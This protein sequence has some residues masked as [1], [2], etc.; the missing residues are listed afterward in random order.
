[1]FII[2]RG[3][4]VRAYQKKNI[5]ISNTNDI[6][7]LFSNDIPLWASFALENNV[8]K[9]SVNPKVSTA[10]IARFLFFFASETVNIALSTSRLSLRSSFSSCI[11]WIRSPHLTNKKIINAT[12]ITYP[13]IFLF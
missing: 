3:I 4:A 10:A 9:V 6:P 1:M 5:I 8:E 7:E 12:N 11:L 13:I 2:V